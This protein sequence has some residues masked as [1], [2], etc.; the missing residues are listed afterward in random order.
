[1]RVNSPVLFVGAGPGDPDLIT[2][3]G[4]KAL[5]AADLVVVAGSLVN[6]AIH[7]DLKAEAKLIDSAPLALPEIVGHLIQGYRDGL[8]VVRLH[9]GDPSL[10]GAIHEQMALLKEAGVPYKAIPGVT[11]ALAAAAALAME[12]TI[13]EVTQTLILTRAAGRTPTPAG[14]SLEALAAHRASMA[15]YLSAAQGAEVGRILAAAYGPSAP[16]A[17]CYRVSWPDEKIVWATAA[18]L[19]EALAR[20]S[21]DRH[22]LMLAGPAVEAR[23][24]GGEAPKSRLYDPDFRHIRRPGGEP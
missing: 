22:V 17:L 5:L 20:E 1:M 6:P 19:A 14:E 10:Y 7:A 3:A 2:V 23:Q 12:W 16:V 18:T 4:R 11:S 24:T 15:I 21:L 9:T 8:A 13:P